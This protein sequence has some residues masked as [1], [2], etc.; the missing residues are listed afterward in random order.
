MVS[1][2]FAASSTSREP[3]P[4]QESPIYSVI[5]IAFNIYRQTTLRQVFHVAVRSVDVE[6]LAKIFLDGFRLQQAIRR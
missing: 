4:F 5:E 6:T 1:A 3:S 2:D